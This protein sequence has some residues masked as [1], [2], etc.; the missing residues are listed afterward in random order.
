M[1]IYLYLVLFLFLT[2]FLPKKL[3][4]YLLIFAILLILGSLRSIEVGTDTEN[5]YE[6]YQT[7]TSFDALGYVFALMEPS[8]VLMNLCSYYLCDS[9]RGV[10]WGGMLLAMMPIFIRIW[11]SC[12][13]PYL[14]I[15][16]YVLLYFYFN[17]YNITRQMIAVSFVFYA[18]PFLETRNLKRFYLF[19]LLAMTFHYTSAICLFLP[20]LLKYFK[21]SILSVIIFLSV[22]YVLG[23]TL[24]P[25]LIPLIPFVGKYSVYLADN[26]EASGSITRLLLNVFFVFLYI[27]SKHNNIYIKLLFGG[28]LFYN[29]FA[30]SAVLGR[31]SVFFMIAQLILFCNIQSQ[32]KYNTYIQKTVIFLYAGCY[33]FLL[34]SVNSNEIVPYEFW[35]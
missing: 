11:K 16:F 35:K 4:L 34:L 30:F 31:C 13:N 27:S 21:Q 5:Y 26:A 28:I 33:F 15:L 14:G 18:L 6:W 24:I 17:A 2:I 10:I 32:F 20:L 8:W 22:S 12:N 25:R 1:D 9:Y 23:I 29:L 19:V 7:I 3:W